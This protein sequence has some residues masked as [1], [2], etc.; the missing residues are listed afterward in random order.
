MGPR[1]PRSSHWASHHT[2]GLKLT[3]ASHS[4]LGF[5]NSHRVLTDCLCLSVLDPHVL[6][7]TN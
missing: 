7:S 4:V 1:G 3:Q 5:P 6:E 2:L